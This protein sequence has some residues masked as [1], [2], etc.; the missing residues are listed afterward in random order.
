MKFKDALPEDTVV[1]ALKDQG[2]AKHKSDDDYCPIE[3]EIGRQVEKEHVDSDE[4]AKEIAKDHL[5][6]RKDYYTEILAPKEK[7]V[8]DITI[9][10]LKKNGYKSLEDFK[11]NKAK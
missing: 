2:K 9:K 6:E 1:D 10:V 7:E 3:L 11:N 8:M 4:A 5:S